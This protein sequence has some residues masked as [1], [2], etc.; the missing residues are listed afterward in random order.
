MAAGMRKSTIPAI[1]ID[2]DAQPPPA[3]IEDPETKK[4]M[5]T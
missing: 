3:M 2:M 4:M 5:N 1:H